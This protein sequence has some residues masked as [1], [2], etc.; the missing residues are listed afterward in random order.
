MIEQLLKIPK[1]KRNKVKE[2]TLDMASSMKMI[3]KKCFPKAIQTHENP[4]NIY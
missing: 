4:D 3:T 1:T 2:I